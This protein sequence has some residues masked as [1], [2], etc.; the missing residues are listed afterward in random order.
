MRK[1]LFFINFFFIYPCLGMDYFSST[2]KNI[3]FSIYVGNVDYSN[4]EKD[5]LKPV[6]EQ[7]ISWKDD[8]SNLKEK[9]PLLNYNLYHHR[10]MT[11]LI[12]VLLKKR[13]N[14]NVSKNKRCPLYHAI[15]CCNTQ[16]AEYLLQ[17]GA[18]PN[19]LV[20]QSWPHLINAISLGNISLISC[21][22]FYG[23]DP[24]AH[25]SQAGNIVDTEI[26]IEDPSLIYSFGPVIRFGGS[27]IGFRHTKRSE[28]IRLLLSYNANTALQDK[29]G[30]TALQISKVNYLNSFQTENDQYKENYRNAARILVRNKLLTRML[31][32]I[33][34]PAQTIQIIMGY[35]SSEPN[36]KIVPNNFEVIKKD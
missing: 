18:E 11:P 22:L 13:A 7:L 31:S 15:S 35:E 1:K 3:C 10:E 4:L 20:D 12:S 36:Q 34:L 6:I 19:G 14:P 9:S 23:A 16:A 28:I 17:A 30:N 25:F 29:Q 21:L 33:P 5:K 8:L 24:D 27:T 32:T 2:I 26:H